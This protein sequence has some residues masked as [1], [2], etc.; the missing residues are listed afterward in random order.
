LSKIGEPVG[1]DK[2][3]GGG[4]Q[5]LND[6][7]GA[8]MAAVEALVVEK[9]G[10]G[11]LH[12]GADGAEPGAVFDPL[13]PDHGLNALAQAQPAIVGAVVAGIPCPGSGSTSAANM[14]AANGGAKPRARCRS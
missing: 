3:V 11:I 9:L 2:D 6:I 1:D 10:V 7:G 13:V 8:V 5:G 14:L 4:E 12:D